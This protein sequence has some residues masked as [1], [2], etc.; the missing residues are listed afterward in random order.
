[1]QTYQ[2]L[3]CTKE[4]CRLRFPIAEG[5]PLGTNCP[6]CGEK[7]QA[8]DEVYISEDARE[9]LPIPLAIELEVL[10]DNVRSLTN[11]G[12]IF[13]TADG[14]GIRHLYLG[15]ITP[16]PEHP[17]MKKTSLG[18]EE[19]VPWT[20]CPNGV[21][22]ALHC[23]NNGMRLWALEGGGRSESLFTNLSSPSKEPML[24]VVGHEVSGIDPRIL[25][26]CERVLRVPMLGF[27]G[28]LNVSVAFGIAAYC[29]RFGLQQQLG[30]N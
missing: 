21:E 10:L 17:R 28:S 24:L 16:T 27:K 1:M 23:K 12:S 22:T 9:Q 26:L 18:A 6:Y 14:V 5:S 15:G 30:K 2:T 4:S 8:V 13:R 7:T 29:L 11:V 19:R 20:K 3:Q 25:S